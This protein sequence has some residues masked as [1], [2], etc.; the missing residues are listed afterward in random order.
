[1]SMRSSIHAL[2]ALVLPP[3]SRP[4]VTIHNYISPASSAFCGLDIFRTRRHPPP[5]P[6]LTALRQR[7][8]LAQ[9][10]DDGE[11][12]CCRSQAEYEA[13]VRRECASTGASRSHLTYLVYGKREARMGTWVVAR[14]VVFR[15]GGKGLRVRALVRRMRSVQALKLWSE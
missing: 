11:H 14:R 4:R 13:D 8:R 9:Y 1:M 7:A 15:P 5:L 6:I 12:A 10:T 3:P 2:S